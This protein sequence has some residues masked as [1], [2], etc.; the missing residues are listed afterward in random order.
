[1]RFH[2]SPYHQFENSVQAQHDVQL[3]G[4]LVR[5]T[6]ALLRSWVT[7]DE[8]GDELDPQIRRRET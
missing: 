5:E 6:T 7:I 3:Q 2:V 8:I 4:S 1:M